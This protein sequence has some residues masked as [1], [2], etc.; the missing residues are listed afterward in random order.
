M[1]AD[2]DWFERERL[3]RAAE[4]G[5]LEEVRRLVAEG[6][7]LDAFDEIAYTPLHYASTRGHI[8][9]MRL[10][11]EAGAGIDARDEEQ[12]GDTPLGAAAQTCT[13]EV[14]KILIEAGADPTTPGW[15][16]I[17]PL[18]KA[19]ERKR[20][21]GIEVFEYLRRATLKHRR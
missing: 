1:S 21:D 19:A 2:D 15:M 5:D 17:R 8:A 16:Q 4:D 3:H 10:L 12:I 14:A 6:C 11:I 13:L 7:D 18:D 20:P 9:V